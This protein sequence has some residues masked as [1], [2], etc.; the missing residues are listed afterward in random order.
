MEVSGYDWKKVIWKV[1]GSNSVEE[2]KDNNEIGLWGL[3]LICLT[4]TRVG[5]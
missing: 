2:Q 4:R 1:V 5:W 3:I